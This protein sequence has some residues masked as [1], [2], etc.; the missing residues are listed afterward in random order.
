MCPRRT[1]V[2]LPRPACS[3]NLSNKNY[4]SWHLRPTEMY[5]VRMAHMHLTDREAQRYLPG[6]EP[7]RR[8]QWG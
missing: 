3:T 6:K 8:C 5:Q 2:P 1:A 7:A 4:T